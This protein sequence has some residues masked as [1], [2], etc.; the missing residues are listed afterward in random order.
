[1]A[2]VP[3][4][5]IDRLG[6]E[7]RARV[8]TELR[9]QIISA[10][11]IEDR[12]IA[13]TGRIQAVRGFA[14]LAALVGVP[15][16]RLQMVDGAEIDQAHDEPGQF[17]VIGAE[18][19]SQFQGLDST[20][21]WRLYEAFRAHQIEAGIVDNPDGSRTVLAEFEPG[22]N[23]EVADLVEKVLAKEY[24]FVGTKSGQSVARSGNSN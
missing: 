16:C 8:R 15:R 23:E 19:I 6:P 7:D 3:V 10:Y 20:A 24:D 18:K 13:I 1:M 9:R 17:K 12:V 2:H 21:G 14:N 4:I 11:E 5:V 22:Q